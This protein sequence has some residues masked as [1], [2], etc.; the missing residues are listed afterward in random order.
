MACKIEDFA[1]DGDGSETSRLPGALNRLHCALDGVSGKLR[2]GSASQLL[3]AGRGR[4]SLGLLFGLNR[5][6]FR[7]LGNL[8]RGSLWLLGSFGCGSLRLLS[9]LQLRGFGR[10]DLVSWSF[11]LLRYACR[12][13]FRRRS[14][15]VSGSFRRVNNLFA[16]GG[17]GLLGGD[18]LWRFVV[19]RFSWC[20]AVRRGA[21]RLA[22]WRLW[23]STHKGA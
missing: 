3:F 17:A 16:L 12:R 23:W 22:A 1:I 15:L 8:R 7:L 2:Y 4:W 14:G 18:R 20:R 10:C 9:S 5:R 13:R 21:L 19:T 6:R 11:R